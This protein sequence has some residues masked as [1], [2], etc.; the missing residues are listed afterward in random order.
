MS[1]PVPP[2]P[3]TAERIAG[4]LAD[5]PAEPALTGGYL[6]LLGPRAAPAP[7][8]AQQVMQSTLLPQIYERVWRPVAFNLAKGWPA[9]PGTAAEH[10]L[11]REWLGLAQPGDVRKPAAT[12]LDVA[13]GPGNVTRALAA[14]VA[15]NGLVVGLDAAA[16][17]LARAAA[18]SAGTGIGYVRGDAVGL[19]FQD[20]SF[21]AVCCFGALYLFDDPWA[22]VDSM[23]RVLKPGG[24]LVVLTTRRPAL[25]VSRASSAIFGALAGVRMFGD[26]EVTAALADR[27]LTGIEHRRYPF[28]QLAAGRRP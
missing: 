5:P 13:C 22:A 16:G 10:A 3:S 12:V 19:P 6:D 14:G 26:H 11:A 18:D 8:I 25:P 1:P 15:E 20:A 28:L 17:M 4:L 24:R 21:D 27:G 2:H 9:G 7:T 23:V